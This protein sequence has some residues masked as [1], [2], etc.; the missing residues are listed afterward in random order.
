MQVLLINKKKKKE[1][2]YPQKC[3]ILLKPNKILK[4]KTPEEKNKLFLQA[5]FDLIYV[6][7]IM[8]ECTDLKK[9]SFCSY[10]RCFFL[11]VFL[12]KC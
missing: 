7:F 4:L 12:I 1:F 6:C 2:H 5:I 11:N 8:S 10:F 9:I 3:L